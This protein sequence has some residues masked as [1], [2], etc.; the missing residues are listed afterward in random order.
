M[1]GGAPSALSGIGG[2]ANSPGQPGRQRL[3]GAG[4]RCGDSGWGCGRWGDGG[5]RGCGSCGGGFAGGTSGWL[6][7]QRTG[8]LEFEAPAVVFER[9]N[10]GDHGESEVHFLEAAA[11][12]GGHGVSALADGVERGRIEGIGVGGGESGVSV[13]GGNHFLAFLEKER[14]TKAVPEFREAGEA[15]DLDAELGLDE[16]AGVAVGHAVEKPVDEVLALV[17]REV[18]EF[19]I[20]T[21]LAE[22]R[23]KGWLVGA[24]TW[25]GLLRG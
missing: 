15:T 2:T 19:G 3:G 20:V 9:T 25:S 11:R 13:G 17:F 21:R 24:F 14:G 10:L 1:C 22:A 6:P 5:G 23:A 16:N 4:C 7:A 18:E 8:L 12:R